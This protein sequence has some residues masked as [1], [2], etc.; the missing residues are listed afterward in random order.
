[1]FRVFSG[2]DRETILVRNRGEPKENRLQSVKGRGQ[3]PGQDPQSSDASKDAKRAS[4]AGTGCGGDL[5][6]V[7]HVAGK[8]SENRHHQDGFQLFVVRAST[9]KVV[10]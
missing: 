9:T 2:D 7:K 6:G 10:A 4:R 5:E 3:D 1:M 8:K